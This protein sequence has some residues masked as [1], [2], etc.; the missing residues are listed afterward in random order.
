LPQKNIATYN[1]KNI[2]NR[3][4]NKLNRTELEKH[5]NRLKAD[6]ANDV[7]KLPEGNYQRRFAELLVD[8]DPEIKDPDIDLEKYRL[9]KDDP[10]AALQITNGFGQYVKDAFVVNAI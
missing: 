4:L 2:V 10:V 7:R 6:A 3:Y 8:T 5:V 9:E 1:I